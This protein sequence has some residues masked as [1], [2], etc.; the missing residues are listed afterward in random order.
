MISNLH[1]KNFHSLPTL[2]L[3]CSYLDLLNMYTFNIAYSYIFSVSYCG[4][5]KHE[6]GLC[7]NL[8][9]GLTG[10]FTMFTYDI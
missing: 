4:R 6:K 1:I 10:Q 8:N 7:Q 2:L 9:N 3:K 5:P